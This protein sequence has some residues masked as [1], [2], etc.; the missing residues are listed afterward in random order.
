MHPALGVGSSNV[1]PEFGVVET[2]ACLALAR[3]ERALYDAGVLSRHGNLS[4]ALPRAAVETGRWR[5][6]MVDETARYDTD[7]VLEDAALTARIAEISG[8]YTFEL[9]TVAAETQ[10]LFDNLE[11]AGVPARRYVVDEIKR[12]IGRYVTS[13]NLRGLTGRLLAFA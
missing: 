12:S 10:A 7:R 11:A 8:H 9:P 1:A 4:Q 13:Y 2:R 6:W 3:L 5:K